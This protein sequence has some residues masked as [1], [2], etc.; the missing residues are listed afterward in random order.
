MDTNP[1]KRLGEVLAEEFGA[2][3]APA[4]PMPPDEAEYRQ[5]T[6]RMRQSALCLSGGGVRSAA[7][8]LGVI[9]ALA[10]KRLLSAFDYLSTV[11]GGGFTG[12]W[13]QSLILNHGGAV[14][15]EALLGNHEPAPELRRLRGYTNYLTPQ[16]G[17]L[18]ADTWTGVVLYLRNVLLNWVAFGPLFLLAVLAAI[19]YRTVL[20]KAAQFALAPLFLAVAA[21]CLVVAAVRA[22]KDLP[23]HRPRRNA[24]AQAADYVSTDSVRRWVLQP[25][26]A[27]AF[28][29]PASLAQWLQATGQPLDAENSGQIWARLGEAQDCFVWLPHGCLAWL[30]RWY[31]AV[32][33]LPFVYFATMTM[34]YLAAAFWRRSRDPG[35]K[36]YAENFPAWLWSTVAATAFICIGLLLLRR[37]SPDDLAATLAVLGPFWLVL[38]SML[39]AMVFVG[40]RRDARLGDL[41]REWLA[42]LSALKLRAALLWALFGICCL[43]LPGTVF[44]VPE[45]SL[46]I[47]VVGFATMLSG[48][49]AAWLGKQV[50]SRVEA[51]ASESGT[52]RVPLV[53]VLNALSALFA[54]GLLALLGYWIGELLGQLQLAL[55]ELILRPIVWTHISGWPDVVRWHMWYAA[56]PLPL[57]ALLCAVLWWLIVRQSKR[58]NVNRFSMHGVYRNRLTRAFLGSARPE[59]HP[60]PFTGFDPA[61]NPRLARL[62]IVAGAMRKLFPVINM[63][64]NLTS[65]R[66]SDWAERKAA[67]FTATPLACG[68]A[69]L[70]DDG[71]YV[72]TERYAG[73]EYPTV[74]R[75]ANGD[76]GMTLATAMTISGAAVSPNWG[77]HSSPLTAFLMTLFNVRLGAWLP[78]P[79]V[80]TA[81]AD[82]NLAMP[83][84]ALYS[85][86]G[87]LL[88][89]T[90]GQNPAIYLSDGGH[91]ENLG[92]YEVLR[93]RCRLVVVVDAGQDPGCTFTDLG[94][95]IRKAFI[96]LQVAVTLRH[97]RVAARDAAGNEMLGFALGTIQYPENASGLLLYVKPCWLPNLPADVRAYGALNPEFPHESTLDQW[98][99]E[100]QFESY[101]RLGEFQM[102]Q[103]LERVTPGDLD[104][105]FLAGHRLLRRRPAAE[106]A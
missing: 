5:R 8:C 63:A 18:S 28:L 9:Q 45:N 97:A 46:P 94:N 41:D 44:H 10:R 62:G 67:S 84:N 66:R 15:A 75:G 101:R 25:L 91:F 99:T 90:T 55:G 77:Y 65:D 49:A 48:P 23:S 61:D 56:D 92:L 68:S 1:V 47:W 102:E 26:L 103:I 86:L 71:R 105:L 31:F 17:L 72:C 95:A 13:L 20:W 83:R 12:A 54:V 87:D 80:V 69:V 100:S 78:N 52:S 59:R 70:G 53:W 89:I 58:I 7:F 32:T 81:P 2:I 22:C 29:A 4:D 11:S 35:V 19:F 50:M 37:M 79:A 3:H 36:L 85:M 57:Q 30:P 24:G 33:S 34:G 88:G 40:I 82:L 43:W 51:A 38:S 27:W 106:G 64:L 6:I 98:F 42:R 74:K 93:R 21:A 73:N 104:G 76:G 60:D 14:A 16:M 39:Q 96:D